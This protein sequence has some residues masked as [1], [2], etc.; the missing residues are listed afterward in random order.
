M[1]DP[2]LP[3]LTWVKGHKVAPSYEQ[4]AIVARRVIGSMMLLCWPIAMYIIT[5][6]LAHHQKRVSVV[7][8]FVA[9]FVTVLSVG[10]I[11]LTKQWLQQ[12]KENAG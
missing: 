9:P 7:C 2:P 10:L 8:L 1:I 5:Q 3:H 6:P 11:R 12:R 4:E